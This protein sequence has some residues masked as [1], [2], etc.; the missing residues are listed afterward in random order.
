MH[1][2]GSAGKKYGDANNASPF[3]SDA[4]RC[5]SQTDV[6][7]LRDAF[8]DALGIPTGERNT[9]LARNIADPDERQAIATLLLAHDGDGLIDV[10][11]G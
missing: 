7:R 6:A 8:N 2:E 9:W 4:H 10:D 3:I 1:A 5:F 11:A